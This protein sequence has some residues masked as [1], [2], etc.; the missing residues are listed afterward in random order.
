MMLILKRKM[1]EGIDVGDNVRIV[2][3][4]IAG[5]HVKIGIEAPTDIRVRR[6]E[7]AASIEEENLRAA[8]S[9]ISRAGDLGCLDAITALGQGGKGAC[10]HAVPY[11]GRGHEDGAAERSSAKARLVKR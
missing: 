6:S 7:A 5:G 1:G 10:N 2:L 4:E 11:P 8:E 9:C 3:K